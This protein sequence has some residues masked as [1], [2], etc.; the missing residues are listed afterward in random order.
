MKPGAKAANPQ[1]EHS[2]GVLFGLR[3]PKC[4]PREPFCET[5]PTGRAVDKDHPYPSRNHFPEVPLI[6]ALQKLGR[7]RSV[8]GIKVMASST[9]SCRLPTRTHLR[10]AQPSSTYDGDSGRYLN[11]SG[12]HALAIPTRSGHRRRL[13]LRYHGRMKRR[14]LLS[15]PLVLVALSACEPRGVPSPPATPPLEAPPPLPA[16]T[17]VPT[18]FPA[19]ASCGGCPLLPCTRECLPAL[20]EGGPVLRGYPGGTCPTLQPGVNRYFGSNLRSFLLYVPTATHGP[21]GLVFLWNAGGAAKGF[22]FL[23]TRYDADGYLLVIPDGDQR[24]PLTWAMDAGVLDHDLR[25]FDE[26]VACASE[27]FPLDRRRVHSTG[28]SVGAVFSAYLMAH[29]SDTLASFVGW[30]TG[31]TDPAGR[32]MV[33]RPPRPVPGLLYHGGKED[34]PDWA[35][36]KGTLALATHMAQAG[37]L[38]IVCDHGRGHGLPGTTIDATMGQMW[39]FMFA[40]PF[41]P[42]MAWR[43]GGL[44]GRL[45]DT[46]AVVGAHG[47]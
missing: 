15:V 42:E 44:V 35:G 28:Y 39:S 10:G 3:P 25:F 27:Q 26:V 11:V 41:G 19:N 47:A 31:E 36:R 21:F 16:T 38:A 33:T 14:R 13:A 17:P 43:T 24:Y 4:F 30:S 45:P 32:T 22:E 34:T 8:C 46:C 7:F 20:A 5:S 37:A 2:Q 9:A 12:I 1:V 23:A 40:H 29:R 6:L 18:S